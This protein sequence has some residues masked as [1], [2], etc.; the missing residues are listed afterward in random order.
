[1]FNVPQGTLGWFAG[2][3][4]GAAYYL[5]DGDLNQ[6]GLMEEVLR[7]AGFTT[8][9][10]S[11]SGTYPGFRQNEP[12]TFKDALA[13]LFTNRIEGWWNQKMVQYGVCTQPEFDAA[14]KSL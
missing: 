6:M 8:I 12:A 14:V 2:N 3:K 9:C 1:M 10:R 5:L 7:S 11:S 13:Y 4:G